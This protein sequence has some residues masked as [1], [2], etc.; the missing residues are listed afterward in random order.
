MWIAS[1]YATAAAVLQEVPSIQALKY[2]YGPAAVRRCRTRYYT[3][4]VTKRMH[5]I[6]IS[7]S[8][9][10]ASRSPTAGIGVIPAIL[11]VIAPVASL[12]L[13]VGRSLS[14]TT[15]CSRAQPENSNH[16]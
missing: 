7:L 5:A 4:L 3:P 15:L 8:A 12:Q 1:T 14:Q 11:L 16:S 13:M 6:R 10:N 9:N 2:M